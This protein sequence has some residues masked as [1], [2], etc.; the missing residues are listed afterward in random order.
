MSL[1]ANKLTREAGPVARPLSFADLEGWA[2]DDL[3]AALHAF[4]NTA[5]IAFPH[6]QED[7]DT[8]GRDF[9]ERHFSPPACLFDDAHF[10]GYYEPEVPASRTKS[11]D[12]TAPVYRK[13]ADPSVARTDI[14]DCGAL[15][16]Q[17]LELAWVADEVEAFFLQVQGSGR[18]RFP[19]GTTMR[20]GFAAKN[21]QGYKSIG[22]EL[23]RR[24]EIAG[25]HI[26]AERIKAWVRVHGDEILRHNPSFVYFKS[27]EL[28]DESGPLGAMDRPVTT[29]RTIAVD[30]TYVPLGTPVWTIADG[31]PMLRIAQDIG[32]AIKGPSRA[33]IFCGTGDAAANRAGCLNVTGQ[34][35]AL[36]PKVPQT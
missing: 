10:T 14:M 11:P 32:S 27:L 5:D 19:D 22:Q 24:G 30:P 17:G 36:R 12:F 33:D 31:A 21:G 25:D 16:D 18:L 35:G 1:E 7:A 3:E 34:L 28:I 4:R 15:E 13:P 23:V 8:S 20:I 6:L 2:E 9:F 26:S 29:D